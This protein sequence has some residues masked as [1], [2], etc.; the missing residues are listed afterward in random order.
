[1]GNIRNASFYQHTTTIDRWL[2]LQ[3]KEEW[4]G[5]KRKEKRK[6]RDGWN[7]WSHLIWPALCVMV[8]YAFV[9]L[10]SRSLDGWTNGNGCGYGA[11]DGF[12]SINLIEIQ[13][14]IKQGIYR[15]KRRKEGSTLFMGLDSLLSGSLLF[16]FSFRSLVFDPCLLPVWFGIA[17][18]LI[19]SA[20][21][22]HLSH[23][24][25]PPRTPNVTTSRSLTSLSSSP[26]AR[27]H[28]G[29]SVPLKWPT[30]YCEKGAKRAVHLKKGKEESP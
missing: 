3:K 9:G 4:K 28:T 24:C 27:T 15:E 7:S 20:D 8:L 5:K 19:R 11:R 2:G 17:A 14:P 1:M 29:L 18:R 21:R 13:P 6:E 23:I 10:H 30:N 26:M 22:S 16:L 25:F 12:A